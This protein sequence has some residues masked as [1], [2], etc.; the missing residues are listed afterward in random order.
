[1]VIVPDLYASKKQQFRKKFSEVVASEV[2]SFSITMDSWTLR[3]NDSYITCIPHVVDKAFMHR[4][5]ILACT[6]LA[7][8]HAAENLVEFIG[9]VI[10]DREIPAEET[11]GTALSSLTRETLFWRLCNYRDGMRSALATHFSYASVMSKKMW[12]SLR[13]FVQKRGQL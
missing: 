6:E 3:V 5:H 7:G 2:E 12:C 13:S 1:M 10:E 4:V 8:T 9:T 11:A